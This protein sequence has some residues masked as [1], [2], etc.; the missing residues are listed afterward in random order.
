MTK[1]IRVVLVSLSALLFIALIFLIVTY[2]VG[3]NN[4]ASDADYDAN[5]YGYGYL[6][7]AYEGLTDN[8]EAYLLCGSGGRIDRVYAD[9]GIENMT[10]PLDSVLTSVLVAADIT[11]ISG[12][13]G[14]LMYSLDGKTFELC[15]KVTK[16]DILDLTEFQNMYFACTRDGSVLV[17]GDGISWR[18][19][20]AFA[21]NAIISIA[22]NEEY[23]FAITAET[24]IMISQDGQNWTEQNFND[25]YDGYYPKYVF[26]KLVNLGPSFFILGYSAEAPG[27]PLIM[28]SDSAG[29]VWLF[30]TLAEINDK[31]PEAFYPLSVNHIG[32]FDDQLVAACSGGLL[33]TVTDCPT[34]NTVSNT[35]NAD[36]YTMSLSGK[37]LVVA[38]EDFQF[39]VLNSFD[40][41]RDDVSFDEA[42]VDFQNGAYE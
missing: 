39:A 38:G 40:L 3:S 42:P 18:K 30:K 41:L 26:T 5:Y 6:S 16:S 1:S 14:V 2:V 10:S 32:V 19:Q 7:S 28:F 27:L 12:A 4:D 25:E 17:S 9:G 15:K 13:S 22:S 11:L 31:P 24:D 35:S 29:E 37:H 8:G 21:D 23:L 36:L 34:C 33:L 20:S